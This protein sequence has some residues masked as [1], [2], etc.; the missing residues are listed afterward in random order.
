ML[1][2]IIPVYGR[3]DLLEKCLASIPEACTG[4]P[5]K[6]YVVDD[7]SPGGVAETK[8]FFKSG[9]GIGAS[10][11]DVLFNTLNVGFPASVNK[12]ARKGT[13]KYILLLNSDVVLAPK[14]LDIMLDRM[15]SEPELGVLGMKLLF[16]LDASQADQAIRP[17]GRVQHVGISF[18]I[19]AEAHHIFVGWSADNPRVNTINQ[20]PAVTGAAFL[21]RRDLWKKLRGMD[22]VWGRGTWEDVDYCFKARSVGYYV[23]VATNAVGTHYTGGS[24]VSSG[25]PTKPFP[26]AENKQIFYNR[27]TG[28]IQWSDMVL[29]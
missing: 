4:Y 27:W 17:P 2:I 7:A 12:G 14:S 24:S 18:D 5:F 21:T 1:D 19:H 3:F 25:V 20:V 16:P 26:L 9:A 11:V 8:K 10:G 13:G 6:I 22:V 15:Q 28:Q 23:A 29:L